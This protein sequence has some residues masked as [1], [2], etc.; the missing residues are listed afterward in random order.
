LWEID[1]RVLQSGGR[2]YYGDT[3]SLI[4]SGAELETG[5]DLGALK[6][7]ATIIRGEFVLP[8]LYLIETEEKNEDKQ[9]EPEL[10][11]KSKGLGP[12]IRIGE[13]GDDPYDGQL[14]EKDFFDL[15]RNGVPIQRHRISKLKE[16]LNEYAKKATSFPRI[17]SSPK[18]MQSEYDKRS[19][20]DD[21]DTKPL[22]VAMF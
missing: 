20:K 15:I 16:S 21:F 13:A 19:V 8:K 18:A 12:G 4:C 22:S 2:L 17:I 14:S 7:E 3:D 10:K 1:N 9:L 5:G 6:H 11:I